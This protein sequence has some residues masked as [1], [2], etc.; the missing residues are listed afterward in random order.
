M[1]RQKRPRPFGEKGIFSSFRLLAS[2]LAK[3]SKS[4]ANELYIDRIRDSTRC[5]FPSP[6]GLPRIRAVRNT[7]RSSLCSVGGDESTKPIGGASD[8]KPHTLHSSRACTE[9]SL[10]EDSETP[11][12]SRGDAGFKR[13]GGSF[14]SKLGRRYKFRL[15]IRITISSRD[16]FYSSANHLPLVAPTG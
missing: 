13:I 6:G 10:R 3:E 11:S 15:T 9:S 8:P 14:S 7:I 12:E 16:R 5:G 4:F 1:Q 2:R